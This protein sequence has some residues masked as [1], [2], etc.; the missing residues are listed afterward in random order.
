M[1]DDDY[2][3]NTGKPSVVLTDVFAKFAGPCD[4]I[5]ATVKKWKSELGETFF[6]FQVNNSFFSFFLRNVY[7][8]KCID[9]Y[10]VGTVRSDQFVG[11]LSKQVHPDLSSFCG[12]FTAARI[13]QF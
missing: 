3:E 10:V 4:S 2:V 8:M 6:Y 11:A 5:L 1:N 7:L 12:T 9:I 13:S